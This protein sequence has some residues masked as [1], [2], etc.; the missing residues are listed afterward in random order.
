MDMR[1]LGILLCALNSASAIV[2]A[3]YSPLLAASNCT[4]ITFTVRASATNLLVD[5]QPNAALDTVAEVDA[6]L[7]ALPEIIAK[8]RPGDRTGVFQL[9]AVYCAPVWLGIGYEPASAT[10]QLGPPIAADKFSFNAS[11][12]LQV[13]VHGSTYTKEYWDL[14]AWGDTN[15]SYSWRAAANAAGYSTLAVDK[16][17]NGYSSHPDPILDVQ[18]PLQIETIHAVITQIKRARAKVSKPESITLVGH[19]SGSILTAA[20]VQSY[21]RDADAVV[22]TAY[23]TRQPSGSPNAALGPNIAP[24]AISDPK[25][26]GNLSYGYLLGNSLDVRTLYGYY[27]GHYNTSIASNDYATRGVQPIGEGFNLGLTDHPKFRGK[28]LVVTGSKDQVICGATPAEQCDPETVTS[29]VM[30]VNSTFP[31]I[32]GFE[33]YT[34]QAGHILNWHYNA[35]SIFDVSLQKLDYLLGR[36]AEASQWTLGRDGEKRYE[37]NTKR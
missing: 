6:Y 32:T 11:L 23:S 7:Q 24:A 16:L 5:Q 10:S 31:S 37:R 13:L 15:T 12:P 14:G 21:P 35:P 2:L 18:L 34:P 28:V 9:A 26:F 29:A 17:G 30:E 36:E 8:G 22:L 3:N 27:A 4:N 25:R 19:S 20:L 1:S 33:Y